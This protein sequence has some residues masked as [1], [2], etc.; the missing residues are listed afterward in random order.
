MIF[1]KKWV[2]ISGTRINKFKENNLEKL[3]FKS[4]LFIFKVSILEAAI[5]NMLGNNHYYDFIDM[6]MDDLGHES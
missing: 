6:N 1:Q 4:Q 5:K 3:R 2:K